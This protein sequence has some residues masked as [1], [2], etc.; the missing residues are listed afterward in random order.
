MKHEAKSCSRCGA[1]FHCS[2][3]SQCWCAELPRLKDVNLAHD[4][5][6]PECLRLALAAQEP[7]RKPKGFTLIELLVVIAIIALLATLLLPALSNSKQSAQRIR[8]VNN[9]RQLGLAAQMYFDDNEGR[10]FPFNSSATNNGVI[11]WFGWLENGAEG[12]REFDARLGVLFPYIQGR[13]IE[14][15][16]SLNYS[17][18]TFK[19]KAR[20]AAYGY[21][22][23]RHIASTNGAPAVNIQQIRDTSAIALFAD[24]AQINDFQSPASPDNPMLEEFFYVDWDTSGFGYPNGHFRHARTANV[25]LVDGHVERIG[26]AAGTLDTR[27]PSEN[28][29]RLPRAML[30]P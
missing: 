10:T 5:L 24:A 13:G 4:C 21:G 28:V 20:G 23:N 25:A 2:N 9:L 16:P 18:T 29:A 7:E 1:R 19:F 8:C 27:L 3:S 17:S 11:Y 22:Y 12:E 30:V 14:I 26:P 15:C 6:C